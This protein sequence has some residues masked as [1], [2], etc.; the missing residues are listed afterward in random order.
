VESVS[1]RQ[2]AE[3]L[4]IWGLDFAF[5]EQWEYGCRA[6]TETPWPQGADLAA[7]GGGRGL[8]N[9]ADLAAI[10]HEFPFQGIVAQFPGYRDGCPSHASVGSFPA[11]SFGLHETNGN[12]WEWCRR[13]PAP[14]EP[15]DGATAAARGGSF[16]DGPL[17]ARSASRRTMGVDAAYQNVGLRVARKVF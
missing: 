17:E 4:R 2:A 8:L 7:L 16:A 15:E 5:E 13:H 10:E 3:L 12:V 1:W 9:V 14:G 11:N 6:E